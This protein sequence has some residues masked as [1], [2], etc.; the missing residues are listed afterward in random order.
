MTYDP[1]RR[2]ISTQAS[3]SGATRSEPPGGPTT[4]PS[5]PSANPVSLSARQAKEAGLLTSGTYDPQ[6]TISSASAALQSALASRLRARTA[7]VGSILY[8]LTWKERATP[9]GR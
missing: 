3:A 7:L 5:G 1:T 8:K 4:G 9:S 6:P 2:S